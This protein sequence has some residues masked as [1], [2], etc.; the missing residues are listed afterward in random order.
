MISKRAKEISREALERAN[1][2]LGEEG[3][4]DLQDY[5]LAAAVAAESLA[6]FE[7]YVANL[8]STDVDEDTLRDVKRVR[9]QLRRI[10]PKREDE[11]ATVAASASPTEA[12]QKKTTVADADGKSLD[13]GQYSTAGQGMSS[14]AAGKFARLMGGGKGGAAAA[15]ATFAASAEEEERRQREIQTQF[16][17]AVAH[18]GKKGLGK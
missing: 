3:T 17:A 18:K 9:K 15:H 7:E 12:Q 6:I 14:K 16:E 1:A 5:Q 8:S 2:R 10:V 4:A 11:A 13:L